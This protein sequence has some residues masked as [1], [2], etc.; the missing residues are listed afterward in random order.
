MSV[1]VQ[2]RNRIANLVC[3]NKIA[4]IPESSLRPMTSVV[5]AGSSLLNVTNAT[6]NIL[7]LG[8]TGSGKSTMINLLAEVALVI[9]EGLVC[10]NSTVGLPMSGTL[11]SETRHP[12]V[13]KSLF[14]NLVDVP[15]FRD[16][17]GHVVE[18]AN[19]VTLKRLLTHSKGL[20]IVLVLNFNDFFHER[21]AT[22]RTRLNDILSAFSNDFKANSLFFVLNKCPPTPPAHILNT[23]NNETVKQ[24]N[25]Q[26]K[27]IIVPAISSP[28]ALNTVRETFRNQFKS[29]L[30]RVRFQTIPSID[31]SLSLAADALA[32]VRNYI[33]KSMLVTLKSRMIE[34]WKSF[35]QNT[36][37]L[38]TKK[39][40]LIQELTQNLDQKAKTMLQILP[41][42]TTKIVTDFKNTVLT[43]AITIY[44]REIQ[45]LNEKHRLIQREAQLRQEAAAAAEQQ[46]IVEQVKSRISTMLQQQVER[47]FVE[48]LQNK[49][50]A[51][52]LPKMD[53]IKARIAKN[54]A[55]I[56]MAKDKDIIIFIGNTGSG[57]ST[58]VNFVAGKQVIVDKNSR[59]NLVGDGVVMEGGINSVTSAPQFLTTPIG[60]VYDLPGF[61][62]TDSIEAAVLNCVAARA[63]FAAAKSVKVVLVA[64][65]SELEACRGELIPAISNYISLLGQ[66]FF[67][68]SLVVVLNQFAYPIN[69][70]P[71]VIRRSQ[72]DNLSTLLQKGRL[73]SLPYVSDNS[74]LE[75]LKSN[76]S[77]NLTRVIQSLQGKR[78][79]NSQSIKT[80]DYDRI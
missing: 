27:L 45:M 44:A 15:G 14:G 2:D 70:L 13:M 73:I 22:M 74:T 34:N 67:N 53:S 8:L 20:V 31:L 50:R 42:I 57:K 75:S 76:V 19:N 17:R 66:D 10:L 54:A 24:M 78:V 12:Q 47:E 21:G 1:S 62:T 52:K 69:F 3:D 43:E 37:E 59:M 26:S 61:R 60:V 48:L 39:D 7:F 32:V 68:S 77:S 23:T 35:D 46:R 51:S 30:A 25:A 65:L 16:N 5:D 18:L 79:E 36:S 6:N 4:A 29:C 58:L 11:E 33:T 64:S 41:N 49:C 56:A 9:R 80:L 63:L 38:N 40:Q 28:N 71:G 72:C 55:A